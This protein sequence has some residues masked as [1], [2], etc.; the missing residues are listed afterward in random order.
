LRVLGISGSPRYNSNTEILLEQVLKGA[1]SHGADTDTLRV[2]GLNI[3]PCA[4]CDICGRDGLC[5]LNDDMQAVFKA[6][7]QADGIV[8]AA[9]LH[10][11]GIPSQMKALIDRAQPMWCRKY[12]LKRLPLDD[13]R[14]RLAFFVS[15]GGRTGEQMF[16]AAEVTVKAFFAC[17]DIK[18]TGKLV[19]SGIEKCAQVRSDTTALLESFN[20]GQNL[21]QSIK[22][23]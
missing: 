15:V 6:I 21:A 18:Y 12:L 20:A 2:C 7:E 19:F 22:T 14:K 1:E 11:M 16:D 17:L 10:F 9:P 8:L 23:A 3:E 4:H 5:H 13:K